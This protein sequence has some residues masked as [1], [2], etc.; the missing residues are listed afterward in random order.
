MIAMEVMASKAGIPVFTFD[1]RLV[2]DVERVVLQC[3][4]A[5]AMLTIGDIHSDASARM[6]SVA[7]EALVHL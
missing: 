6:L 1:K 7:P 3:E 2:S 5:M 4:V